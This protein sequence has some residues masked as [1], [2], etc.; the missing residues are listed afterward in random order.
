MV[1]PLEGA[2]G[3]DEVDGTVP[4]PARVG[5]QLVFAEESGSLLQLQLVEAA[6][7]PTVLCRGVA[8][9]GEKGLKRLDLHTKVR[10]RGVDR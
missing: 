6:A 4:R 7:S 2:A 5:D 1:H 3:V 9:I 8:G 10:R